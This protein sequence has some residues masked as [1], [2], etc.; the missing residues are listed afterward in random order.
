[1][2][3]A[4]KINGCKTPVRQARPGALSPML[5][6]LITMACYVTA[7]SV[8]SA[9]SPAKS[10]K[11][12][13]AAAKTFLG[14]A[15]LHFHG[16]PIPEF[17][18]ML[19]AVVGGS[20]MGPGEGWFHNGEAR[21]DWHWLAAR[22]DADHDGKITR[23][24]FQGPSALFDRLDRN[25]DGELTAS[26]FDWSERS[27]YAM[28][29]MPAGY[30]F[31]ALDSNSNGRVSKEEWSAYFAKI[32]KGKDYLTPDD[33]REAFPVAPPARPK[34]SGPVKNQGPSEWTLLAGL[35]KGELGSPF[36]G[37]HVGDRAP[38]FTLKT[39]DGKRTI[40]LADFRGKKP[41]VLVFGSFT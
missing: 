15:W 20:Q 41:V 8:S 11:P 38:D 32:S 35:L 22:C 14:R 13:S 28:Q 37:P 34:P 12:S 36:S 24:E 9:Q 6:L 21:H 25:H 1:M 39:E 17:V 7:P 27:S 31:R 3:H 10:S 2:S 23:K 30:W 29:G 18:E 26:D 16:G 5:S 40:R 19:S 33:I 4:A